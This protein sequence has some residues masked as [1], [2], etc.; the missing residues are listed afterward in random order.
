MGH[1]WPLHASTVLVNTDTSHQSQLPFL[2]GP[3][4]H[5][6][7]DGDGQQGVG[8]DVERDRAQVVDRGAQHVA[9]LPGE[10]AHHVVVHLEGAADNGHQEI[11]DL[12][13]LDSC[14]LFLIFRG[15]ERKCKDEK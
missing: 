6:P 10:L 15:T 3:H 13:C 12:E 9:V 4:P 7:V 11:R 1:L 5:S 2:G 8:G 14:K